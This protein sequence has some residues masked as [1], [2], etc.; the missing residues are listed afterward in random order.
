MAAAHVF[1]R[2]A[3]THAFKEFCFTSDAPVMRTSELLF[4]D[5][6]IFLFFSKYIGIFT[7]NQQSSFCFMIKSTSLNQKNHPK[8]VLKR[9]PRQSSRRSYSI[10]IRF[11]QIQ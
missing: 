2:E 7:E 10:A 6:S 4:L 9:P 5:S 11:L 1:G 3:K 8:K